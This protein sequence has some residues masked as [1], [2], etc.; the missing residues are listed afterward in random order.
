M[1]AH[2]DIMVFY[3][4]LPT[5]NP[6]KTTG[7]ERKTSK[8]EHHVG[9]KQGNYGDYTCRMYDSTER[10]PK[11]VWRFKTDKQKLAIHPQQKPVELCR[12]A[13]RTYTNEG[14]VVLDNCC[15]SGSIVLAAMLENRH[16]I[17]MD[18]G[19]DWKTGRRWAEI[20]RERLEEGK[21]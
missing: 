9:A 21:T 16:F 8:G 2:E 4:K 13:I 15:G 1:R 11:S 19:T 18:N 5:Y 12:Y 17:G 6:Q 20:A 10:Y 14:D 3:K 7:H